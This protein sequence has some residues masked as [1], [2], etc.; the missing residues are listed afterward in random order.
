MEKIP[1]HFN[2]SD[3]PSPI[4][5]I[6]F[7]PRL[8]ELMRK[9]YIRPETIPTS[10]SIEALRAELAKMNKESG[11]KVNE[12]RHKKKQYTV[13]QNNISSFIFPFRVYDQSLFHSGRNLSFF[14]LDMNTEMDDLLDAVFHQEGSIS[15]HSSSFDTLFTGHLLDSKIIDLC[16]K[17]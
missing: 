16:L 1:N 4:L 5:Q 12:C 14:R 7:Y 10:I 2:P 9:R 13:T 6:K 15:L 3:S 8:F 11:V 17:W